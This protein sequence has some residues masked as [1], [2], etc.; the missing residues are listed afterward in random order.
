[1]GEE[2]GGRGMVLVFTDATKPWGEEGDVGR[3]VCV[4]CDGEGAR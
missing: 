1:M 4:E 3:C 2:D